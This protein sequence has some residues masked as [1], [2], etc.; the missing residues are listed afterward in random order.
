MAGLPFSYKH[1]R[2]VRVKLSSANLSA[3][4]GFVPLHSIRLLFKHFSF[5]DSYV[6]ILTNILQSKVDYW[7]SAIGFCCQI[8]EILGQ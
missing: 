8:G 3:Y 1:S 2:N 6:T 5:D 7:V 4:Q